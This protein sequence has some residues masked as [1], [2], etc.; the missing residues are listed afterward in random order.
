MALCKQ[1]VSE[2]EH[3]RDKP[4]AVPFGWLL[5]G[6]L[7][8]TCNCTAVSVVGAII[9]LWALPSVL[10]RLGTLACCIR[11]RRIA[12]ANDETSIERHCYF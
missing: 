7:L 12:R 3:Y 10:R 6:S 9:A 4:F 8:M 1:N 11:K 5:L 2:Q